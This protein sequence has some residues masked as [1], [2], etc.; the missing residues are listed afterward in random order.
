MLLI[1]QSFP[2]SVNL[3]IMEMNEHKIRNTISELNVK[4][5]IFKYQA[6]YNASDFEIFI[7]KPGSSQEFAACANE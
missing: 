7:S 6:V 4:T 3:L 2:P 5:T 1:L